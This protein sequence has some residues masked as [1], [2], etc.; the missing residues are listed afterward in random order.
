MLTSIAPVVEVA[1]IA[2]L[3]LALITV[4]NRARQRR[5]RA[6]AID[7]WE[8][9]LGRDDLANPYRV[10]EA[11]EGIAGAIGVALV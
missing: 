3:G 10:Q 9:R 7:R 4:A 1:A 11:F 2:T 6:R 8:L 5:S